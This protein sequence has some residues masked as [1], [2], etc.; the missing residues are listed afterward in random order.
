MS[1][2]SFKEPVVLLARVGLDGTLVRAALEE[3]L[4]NTPVPSARTE[5]GTRKESP[6]WLT[7][8]DHRKKY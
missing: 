3:V 4:A 2:R 5:M 7:M 1:E 6:E 8:S